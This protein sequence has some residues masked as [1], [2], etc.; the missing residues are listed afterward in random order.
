MVRG[1]RQKDKR[2]S[3]GKVSVGATKESRSKRSF[4]YSTEAPLRD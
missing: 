2:L 1:K 4:Q 3:C